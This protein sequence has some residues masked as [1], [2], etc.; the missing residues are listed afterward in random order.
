MNIG[1]LAQHI[2]D[3]HHA[4]LREHIPGINAGL[5]AGGVP[6]ELVDT[7]DQLV[8]IIQ[9]HLIK[10]EQIL[11]PAILEMANGSGGGLHCGFA[12][13]INQMQYEH[14]MLRVLEA[15]LRELAPQAGE[16]GVAMVALLD[17]LAVHAG[18]EDDQL[19][20]AVLGAVGAA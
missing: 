7:W 20:P 8:H 2:L 15:R 3:T 14:E 5:H 4:Y 19:F 9:M 12:G 10:E 1:E 18:L 17:D 13:P 11:F 6:T 16:A